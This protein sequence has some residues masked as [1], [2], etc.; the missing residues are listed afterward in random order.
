VIVM[1]EKGF[2]DV[3]VSEHPPFFVSPMFDGVHL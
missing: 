2:T 3:L 1:D